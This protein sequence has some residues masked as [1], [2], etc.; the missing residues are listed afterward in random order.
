MRV[1]RR[2]AGLSADALG[3]ALRAYSL[4]RWDAA[5]IGQLER[6]EKT[7]VPGDLVALSL[8]MT[9]ICGRAITVDDLFATDAD[10]RL[11]ETHALN[12]EVFRKVLASSY[13]YAHLNA[14][15]QRMD[16]LNIQLT[17]SQQPI[18]KL[19]PDGIRQANEALWTLQDKRAQSRLGLTGPEFLAACLAAWGHLLSVEVE[20]RA[21]A[22]ASPQ[23]KGRI[24][25]ELVK[26]LEAELQRGDD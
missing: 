13:D 1:L 15:H 19:G 18:M 23:K 12:P 7:V 17:T 10:I 21:P 24:T 26:E 3:L 4:R 2:Q 8:A 20:Q 11:S 6:G 25:R 22:N 9:E 14:I 5:Q 16:R